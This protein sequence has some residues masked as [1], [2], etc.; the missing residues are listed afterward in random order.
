MKALTSQEELVAPDT[1][2]YRS[3]SRLFFN[4]LTICCGSFFFGY[5]IAYLSIF[6][7]EQI[8][9]EFNIPLSSEVAS[10]IFQGVVPMG[11]LVG[12]GLSFI[13]LKLLSRR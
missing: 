3:F 13:V 1:T 7:I 10:G 5:G 11:A 6:P 8:I 4:V 2:T 9:T 12:A